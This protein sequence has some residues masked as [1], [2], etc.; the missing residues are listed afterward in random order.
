VVPGEPVRS[1]VT[2]VA[3]PYETFLEQLNNPN[4]AES[5]ATLNE[6]Y[7]DKV[8][9][10]TGYHQAYGECQKVYRRMYGQVINGKFTPLFNRAWGT[11][12]NYVRTLALTIITDELKRTGLTEV[13]WSWQLW[14]EKLGYR[15]STIRTIFKDAGIGV[16]QDQ[17][18][19][20]PLASNDVTVLIERIG[21]ISKTD[22]DA[23]A[24][25]FP[26]AIVTSAG[27]ICNLGTKDWKKF[28]AEACNAGLNLSIRY[29]QP[30]RQYLITEQRPPAEKKSR[31]KKKPVETTALPAIVEQAP[32]K[33]KKQRK[34]RKPAEKWVGQFHALIDTECVPVDPTLPIEMVVQWEMFDLLNGKNQEDAMLDEPMDDTPFGVSDNPIVNKQWEDSQTEQS[35]QV[36]ASDEMVNDNNTI[37]YTVVCDVRS[38][39][40]KSTPNE[41]KM[42]CGRANFSHGFAESYWHNPYKIGEDGTREEVI[43]QYRVHL[44]SNPEMLRR[45]PELRGK[46]LGCWCK[47][48]GEACHCDTLAYLANLEDDKLQ[49]IID[50]PIVAELM[51]SYGGE[52][53]SI[54]PTEQPS[55][56]DEPDYPE[57]EPDYYPSEMWGDF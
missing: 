38:E 31:G 9:S 22:W 5:V 24:K 51:C 19:D 26:Q 34:Q 23:T 32:V 45:I 16:L 55:D 7:G 37:P 42:Y 6:L 53:V 30:N 25:G 28:V 43:T 14:S 12:K 21:K 50:D 57:Y 36:T 11:S 8:K 47:K 15:P 10:Q 4:P 18:V 40:W 44:F 54:E 52:V 27:A 46:L 2:I 1:M 41:Q 3:P 39:L 48:D 56:D 20:I 35:D 33:E 29:H 17:N 49:A 13:Q